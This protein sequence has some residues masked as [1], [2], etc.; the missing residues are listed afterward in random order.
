MTFGRRFLSRGFN[1]AFPDC[2]P[3]A[4][5]ESAAACF[6]ATTP[7]DIK[8]RNLRR[9]IRRSSFEIENSAELN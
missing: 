1:G 2:L 7:E 8:V 9:S 4:D 6:I 3:R 5:N